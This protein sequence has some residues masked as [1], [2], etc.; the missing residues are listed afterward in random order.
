VPDQG[1]PGRPHGLLG[2][3]HQHLERAG[4][5]GIP[6]DD[7]EALQLG[8][9]RVHSGGGMKSHRLADLPDRGRIA[10]LAEVAADVV[11]DLPLALRQV[12][13]EVHFPSS[14]SRLAVSR[15]HVRESSAADG[16]FQPA[17]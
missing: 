8:E 11:E 16:Q 2:A 14:V 13:D 1:Q 7:A 9:V 6:L 15:T 12:F 3:L 17:F 5:R 10:V 4:L